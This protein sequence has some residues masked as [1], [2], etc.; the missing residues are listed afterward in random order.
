MK[1]KQFLQEEYLTTDK[2]GYYELHENPSISEMIKIGKETKPGYVGNDEESMAYARENEL[3]FFFDLK[4]K[5]YYAAPSN[6]LH[7][8]MEKAL[9]RQNITVMKMIK[10]IGKIVNGKLSLLELYDYEGSHTTAKE[11]VGKIQDMMKSHGITIDT[12]S[13]L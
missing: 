12:S 2:N 4:G 1:F 3:R 5:K 11:S 13:L 9:A 10:G 6:F 7:C 8:D